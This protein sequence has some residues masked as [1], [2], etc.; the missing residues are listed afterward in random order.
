VKPEQLDAAGYCFVHIGRLVFRPDRE[1]A[2]HQSGIGGSGED[3]AQ[4][5]ILLILWEDDVSGMFARPA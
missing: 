2:L 4:I 1:E 3:I 5:I